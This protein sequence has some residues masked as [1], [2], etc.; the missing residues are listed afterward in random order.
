MD[1]LDYR[2]KFDRWRAVQRSRKISWCEEVLSEAPCSRG[3]QWMHSFSRLIYR[4]CGCCSLEVTVFCDGSFWW[5][6]A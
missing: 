3:V 5:R 2:G 1:L 6:S 4:I